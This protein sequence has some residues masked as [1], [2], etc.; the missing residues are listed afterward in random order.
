MKNKII[1]FII[2]IITIGMSFVF[3]DMTTNARYSS[4][5][6]LYGN[7]HLASTYFQVSLTSAST[8][9]IVPSRSVNVQ[10]QL[11]NKDGNGNINENHL[12]FYFDLLDENNAHATKV[13]IS[14]L[15]IGENSYS[16]VSGKG[17]GPIELAYNG[18]T[19]DIKTVNMVLTCGT[20][21]TAR[22]T[23][24]YKINLLAE[25]AV[26][27]TINK[28]QAMNLN[29]NVV[30]YQITYNLNQGTNNVNNPSIFIEG[31][32]VTLSSPTRSGYDFQ[33]W[34]EESDF[35][36]TQVTE[37]SNRTSDVTLYAKWRQIYTYY[38]QMPPDWY[39]TNVYAYLCNDSESIKNGA[40]PG[41]QM[42]LKDSNKNI[43]EYRIDDNTTYE[44]LNNFTN[45]I[46]SNNIEPG[47]A[48]TTA[49]RTVDLS[50]SLSDADKIFVPELYHS[51]TETRVFGY[52]TT[53]YLY[54]WKNGG[55]AQNAAWP[56]VKMENDI[57]IKPRT[58][59]AIINRNI[60]DRMIFNQ[61]SGN[62][63][64]EDLIVPTYQ[65]LT[66]KMTS[67]KIKDK[68]YK[69][70]SFRY[71]YYG[72]WHEYNTWISSEYTTWNTTGDGKAFRDAQAALG[73]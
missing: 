7:P 50:F 73:Y 42:T 30:L 13:T 61:G 54:L 65:D 66:Y 32:T 28:N 17:Y 23:L 18:S 53:L 41:V 47:D 49:R 11:Q 67:T 25:D 15:T 38:F 2:I 27:D 14:S 24:N 12:K 29:L 69:S 36:G 10:C 64:T 46:F 57:A 1:Y 71:A 60:Y 22:E 37:I 16:Y 5:A 20:S 45:I 33:G 9:N 55:T 34:Y 51:S 4:S 39:G 68:K 48:E 6:N 8:M 72:S 70:I 44:N 52:A 21:F 19:E 40:F 3:S 62:N 63:Q 43:Y 58:H 56:G 31:E 35:S 59:V 26:N